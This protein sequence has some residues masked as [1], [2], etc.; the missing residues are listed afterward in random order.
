M[1]SAFVLCFCLRVM[2]SE[3]TFKKGKQIQNQA[4][5]IISNVLDLWQNGLKFANKNY[6]EDCF[7][8]RVQN[9]VER[10]AMACTFSQGHSSGS[11]RKEEW[12]LQEQ[13]VHSQ[14]QRRTRADELPHSTKRFLHVCYWRK[15]TRILHYRGEATCCKKK[16][17]AKHL[18]LKWDTGPWEWLSSLQVL[19]EEGRKTIEIFL[20]RREW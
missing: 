17:R 11:E 13:S 9:C 7:L 6:S 4:A 15:G 16:F 2:F 20:L 18:M 8:T 14:R 12:S 1:F 19:G 10:A 5:E 3:Y